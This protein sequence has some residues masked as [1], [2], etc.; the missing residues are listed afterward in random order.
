MNDKQPPERG[1]SVFLRAM[2]IGMAAPALIFETPRITRLTPPPPTTRDA[3]A[4]L[5]A[6]RGDW[7]RIGQDFSTVIARETTR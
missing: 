3:R 6:L 4:S 7:E 5:D 1:A 2:L